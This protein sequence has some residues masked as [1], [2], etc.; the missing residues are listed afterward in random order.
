MSDW[1]NTEYSDKFYHL[2]RHA[3]LVVVKDR[4]L[5]A[6]VFASLRTMAE[7]IYE[8]SPEVSR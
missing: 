7:Y 6:R 1:E 2:S 5:G 8:K 4:E 3:E